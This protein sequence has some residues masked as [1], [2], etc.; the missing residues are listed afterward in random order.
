MMDV[1]NRTISAS[2]DHMDESKLESDD[3]DECVEIIPVTPNNN[4]SPCA[5]LNGHSTS[6]ATPSTASKKRKRLSLQEREERDR[7]RISILKIL[8]WYSVCKLC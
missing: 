8:S 2:E 1:E 4:K 5:P 6:P 3:E 7:V